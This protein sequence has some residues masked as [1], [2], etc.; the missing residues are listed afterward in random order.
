MSKLLPSLKERD[1]ALHMTIAETWGV[2]I[3]RLGE[4]ETA[5]ALKT[6]MLD[7]DNALRIWEGLT[8]TQRGALQTLIGASGNQMPLLMFQRFNGQL[9]EMGAGKAEREKPHKNPTSDTEALVYR[10]LIFTRFEHGGTGA[11]KMVYIPPDLLN[12]LPAYKTAY[13]NLEDE[14]PGQAEQAA[15]FVD[16]FAPRIDEI[17]PGE[18]IIAATTTIV[19]DMATLLGYLQ[20]FE[21]SYGENGLTQ[22]DRELLEPHL[23]DADPLRLDFIFGVGV[24]AG[25]IEVAAGK[26]RPRRAETRRW[27]ESNRSEQLYRLATAW[28]QSTIYRDLWHVEGLYPDPTG[29]P[30][31]SVVAREALLAFIRELTPQQG[32][33]SLD[34]FIMM[35]KETEPD[36]QRP[37]GDYD[38]WYIRNAAGEYLQGFQSWDAIEGALIDHYVSQPLHW[39]AL[40]DLASD[41][42][43]LTAYGRAFVS[44]EGWPNVPD[45]EEPI[46]VKPDGTL[47]VSRKV[48]RFE[49]FQAMRFTEWLEADATQNYVLKLTGEGIRRAGEQGIN[50]GHISAFISRMLDGGALPAPI[51]RLL[52][53]WKSGS[54]ASVSIERMYVL[55]TTSP[56]TLDYV[57]D[58]PALRR[59]VGARLGDM[60][61]AV[62]ADQW[63]G[64]MDALGERGIEVELHE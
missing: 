17:D 23:L 63:N 44:D 18:D 33:W 47:I 41:A 49:R 57:F 31:D 10:G 21:G 14:A 35:I 13:E 55:R 48:S 37:G 24:S 60:A 8:D 62:R 61:A 58:T 36:F 52:E 32:W 42:A 27:L 54:S 30:Y 43:K 40:V 46:E 4:S 16:E 53:S 51:N 15:A 1:A 56:E 9:R 26:A 64:L 28:R 2:D 20:V 11:R 50:T 7:Q 45:P 59:Y 5:E 29:F 6:A 12:V 3:L 38:S 19:D 34:E 39:L 25:L 22:N